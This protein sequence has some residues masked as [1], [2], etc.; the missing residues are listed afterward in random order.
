M[1]ANEAYKRARNTAHPDKGG[2]TELFHEV[3]QAWHQAEQ[4]LK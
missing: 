4:E 3:N 1:E 2:D